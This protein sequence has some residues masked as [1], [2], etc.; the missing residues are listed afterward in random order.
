VV[1]WD[2]LPRRSALYFAVVTLRRSATGALLTFGPERPSDGF[3]RG[4]RLLAHSVN[5]INPPSINVRPG[6]TVQMGTYPAGDGEHS[7]RP[8]GAYSRTAA[9]PP[10]LHVRRPN[11]SLDDLLRFVIAPPHVTLGGLIG[12]LRRF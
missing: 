12:C 4:T 7:A 8:S 5:K 2:H 10:E 3:D 1:T 11:L 6:R 9:E